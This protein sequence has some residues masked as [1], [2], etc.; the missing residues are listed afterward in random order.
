[1]AD[2]ENP[3]K[4]VRLDDKTMLCPDCGGEIAGPYSATTS[5]NKVVQKWACTQCRYIWKMVGGFK[6]AFDANPKSFA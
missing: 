3:R 6:T 5:S 4:P 1:M 2:F